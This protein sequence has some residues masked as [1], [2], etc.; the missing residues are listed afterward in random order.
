MGLT[1]P[2]PKV[3]LGHKFSLIFLILGSAKNLINVYGSQS[4]TSKKTTL[5]SC[6]DFRFR[7]KF[8]F[9]IKWIYYT[10]MK[11]IYK[12]L[13]MVLR[14]LLVIFFFFIRTIILNA[15]NVSIS[16][17]I[18]AFK[19]EKV[20]L[21]KK[22]QKNISFDGTVGGAA[23][24]L[25]G[26]NTN[27]S[28]TTNLS[29]TFSFQLKSPGTYK[30]SIR[31]DGYSGIDVKIVHTD[32]GTKTRYESLY[33]ILKQGETS[34]ADIGTLSIND[35]G[36]LR[37]AR[38]K[39]D[40]KNDILES[41]A[42][43]LEK[44]CAINNSSNYAKGVNA[45]ANKVILNPTDTI[46]TKQSLVKNETKASAAVVSIK[47]IDGLK[48]Q[49][50]EAKQQLTSLDPASN[51]Y[52]DLQARIAELEQ[53]I[54]DKE[55]LIALQ[56]NEIAASRKIITFMSLFIIALIGL[57]LLLFYFFKQKKAFAAQLQEK[58][59]KIT[60]I[61]SKLMSSIRYASLIQNGFLQ[62]KKEL[63]QLFK[64]SFIY[65]RPKDILSGD[66][67]WFSKTNAHNIVVVADCT[68]HG[69]PGAMLTVLGHNALN[70]IVNVQG[71]VKP[72]CI[73][74]AL[75]KVIQ[76]A[77]ANN[78]EQLE[79][80]M[81]I[82]VISMKE[83]SDELLLSGLSN[84]LYVLSNKQLQYHAVSPKSFGIDIKDS[85]FV[86]HK[87]KISKN[88]CLFLFSDGYQDQFN[89]ST[90]EVEKFNLSRFEKLLNEI[91]SEKTFNGSESKLN[92][93]LESWKGKH[94][95]IDDILILGVRL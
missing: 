32:A 58:N 57:A 63:K 90:S 69:V 52:K 45:D 93:N 77:F 72:A 79:Y 39:K 16:G 78:T 26:P 88:D 47:N 87:I 6:L 12:V 65:N 18:F 24:N 29:G 30:L 74:K 14:I 23:I 10:L 68:G 8:Y 46:V 50:N 38:N 4:I 22:A 37:Y 36:T 35:G 5:Q 25:N 60:K 75:N 53:Q 86:D 44:A 34:V 91:G 11:I 28:I 64:D 27:S 43:L 42:H 15:Q 82:T 41:N 2:L 13:F 70:E 92:E 7:D 71:E 94:E 55:L 67:Y 48:L 73:L 66:F 49:L 54:K 17:S 62:D 3:E 95:Q 33:F 84:G 61:N 81:D 80:G 56:E 85:D 76:T 21:L 59:T 51:E 89:G 31:R 40:D 20:L 83:G 1:N 19:G 9:I